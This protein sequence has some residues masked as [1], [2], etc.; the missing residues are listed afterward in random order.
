MKN[1]LLGIFGIFIISASIYL[2]LQ[3][4]ASD[5]FQPTKAPNVLYRNVRIGEKVIKAEVRDTDAGRSLGL[6]GKES[7]KANEGM[8]F[9]FDTPTTYGFWMKDMKFAID[10]VWLDPNKRIVWTEKTSLPQHFQKFSCPVVQ[11]FLS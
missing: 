10:I 5:K 6:S 4:P 1:F 2:F 3:Q 8:L 11:H 7:L 9:I